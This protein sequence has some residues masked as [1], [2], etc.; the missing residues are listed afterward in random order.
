[1]KKSIK[2]LIFPVVVM[3]ALLL[4]FVLKL[5]Q[6]AKYE[7]TYTDVFDT[8]TSITVYDKNQKE[9]HKKEE[10]LHNMLLK[11]H[12]EYDIYHSYKG[13]NNIKTINDNAGIQPVKV[14]SE[15]I[16]L[17]KYGKK[18][19]KETK[20]QTNIAFGSVLKV[21][22]KYRTE[23]IDYPEA[24][25]VPSMK[26]LKEMAKYCDIED[27]IIDEK[28]S[29]VYLKKKGM[30]LD[31]GSIGK[32]YAV[33][34]LGQYAKKLGIERALIS[35]GGNVLAIG[36][37]PDQSLWKIGIQNPDLDNEESFIKYVSVKDNCVVTSGDYQRY[38]TVKGKNYCHI[39]DP[40]TLMPSETIHS[41]TVI[42]KKSGYADALST[43]LFNMS[44]EE[45]KALVETLP[46]V[47]A[48]WILKN[49][50]IGYSSGFEQYISQ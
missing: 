39:V 26:E 23:G 29:T 48:M 14:D 24:A 42:T 11:Y 22:H 34:K 12:K 50:K 47:E 40:D 32:G 38:Y 15:I 36:E 49:N 3:V 5:K 43:G 45:G 8:V 37:K 1:M 13:L 35:V 18:L 28:A 19:Y 25:R 41:V 2:A 33:E 46:G 16:E 20:G 4:L 31:V 27:V 30:S 10:K 6:D 9:F 7:A 44:Y 21:W 17:L